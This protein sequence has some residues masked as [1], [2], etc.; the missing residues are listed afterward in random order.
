[1][2]TKADFAAE[3]WQVLQWAVADTIT[4]LSMSEPGFFDTF[5]EATGA[6]KYVASARNESASPLVRDLA[7]DVKPGRD[8]EATA[9]PT[10]M[11]EKVAARLTEAA[12]VVAH[13]AP[14]D[15]GAFKEFLLGLA[16]ATAQA[17]GGVGGT[18][19]AAIERIAAALG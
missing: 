9:N 19:T 16:Q 5:K 11:G 14:D 8:K 4:Y 2:A 18:E 17:A 3:D 10:D 1:M 13:V 7:A 12:G 15:L 6:A